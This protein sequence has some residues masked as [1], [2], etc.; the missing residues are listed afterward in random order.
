MTLR[1]GELV[2]GR[3]EVV[4]EEELF[5]QAR[6]WAERNAWRF[7]DDR[8][9][10]E[11]HLWRHGV[12]RET[13]ATV[14]IEERGPLSGWA[15]DLEN[16]AT[17]RRVL[18]LV[19]ASAATILHVGS[20]IV[21]GE[22]PPGLARG[23]FTPEEAAALAIEAC[24]VVVALHANGVRP[25]C[26]DSRNLRV[27]RDGERHAIR[28]IVP[29]DPLQAVF[30]QID[31][32]KRPPRAS[33]KA[34]A[35]ADRT[36]RHDVRWLSRFFEDLLAG[37]EWPR[38]ASTIADIASAEDEAVPASVAALARLLLSIAS[39]STDLAARVAA[40]PVVE[41]VAPHAA[42][43]WSQVIADGEAQLAKF[44]TLGARRAY[45]TLPL[46]AAYHQR[47][48][49]SAASGA[50]E[51]ALRDAD[52]AIALDPVFLP[53]ATTR[54]ALLDRLGRG[55]EALP[56]LD[57]ALLPRPDV[58]K[59]GYFDEDAELAP[60]SDAERARA[61]ATRGMITLRTGALTAAE[62]DLGRALELSPT[63]LYA[64]GLGAA[65]YALGSFAGAAEAEARSVAQ[66]PGNTRYRWAL[67]GS[68]RKLGREGEARAE[69]ETILAQE[70][71]VAAHRERFDRLFGG[72]V[73]V[74]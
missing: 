49:R 38:A 64:H 14:L 29:G 59:Q 69:A 62:E 48:S 4:D 51:E 68:L 17:A 30:D 11:P 25:S 45:L 9:S 12:D 19:S 46:A 3:F 53:Y 35:W 58:E 56:A 20:G 7:P 27:V 65:R 57:H 72:V 70:P 16:E 54:A 34:I 63:A 41:W 15:E 21:Y 73:E 50:L 32:T 28:W 47:A 74:G 22:P 26:F 18:A 33:R 66:E 43:E 10:H 1:R 13:G 6:W 40:L 44:S 23:T 52:R 55:A 5:D 24:E 8:D 37:A 31:Q 36:V 60:T 67:V 2:A 42:L 71:G 61:H 39:P